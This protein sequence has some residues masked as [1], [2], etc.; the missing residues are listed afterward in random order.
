MF[1]Q[2][3]YIQLRIE[4]FDFKAFVTQATFEPILLQFNR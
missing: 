4:T 3:I 2:K 1:I